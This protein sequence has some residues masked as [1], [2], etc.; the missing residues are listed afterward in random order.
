MGLLTVFLVLSP[1]RKD[2]NEYCEETPMEE[3][4][5]HRGKGSMGFLGRKSVYTFV[6]WGVAQ[7][8]PCG[9]TAGRQVVLRLRSGPSEIG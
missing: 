6:Q 9:A 5:F 1:Y 3:A 4:V 7:P 8:S 2:A